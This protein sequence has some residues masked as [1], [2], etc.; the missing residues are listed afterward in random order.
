MFAAEL[1]ASLEVKT[2]PKGGRSR[3]SEDDPRTL[4]KDSAASLQ[5]L[6][7]NALQVHACPRYPILCAELTAPGL[8]CTAQFARPWE[9]MGQFGAWRPRPIASSSPTLTAASPRGIAR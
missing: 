5:R 8:R 6:A 4:A 1:A 9:C 2:L 7:L 3:G